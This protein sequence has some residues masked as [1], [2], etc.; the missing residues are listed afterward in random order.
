MSEQPAYYGSS[1]SGEWYTPGYILDGVVRA[2]GRIDLD[3]CSNPPPY[4]VPAMCHFTKAD[5][6]LGRHWHG[7]VFMNPP[8]GKPLPSWLNRLEAELCAG[9]VTAAVVLVPAAPET[10]WFDFIWRANAICFV[11][12]RIQFVGAYTSGNTQGSVLAYYG[13]DAGRFAE[14][15][16]GQGRIVYGSPGGVLA[17][18]PM[19]IGLGAA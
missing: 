3:P 8:Y 1:E 5:D 9:R 10:R 2:L 13:P 6:G 15:F 17:T 18:Q 11:R 16:G 7:S 19:L 4:N 12:G 14:V